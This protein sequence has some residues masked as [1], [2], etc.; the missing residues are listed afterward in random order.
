MKLATL[1][2]EPEQ[3]GHALDEAAEQVTERRRSRPRSSCTLRPTTCTSTSAD[4][5]TA[6]LR[7]LDADAPRHALI[8]TGRAKIAM[9]SMSRLIFIPVIDGPIPR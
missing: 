6:A 8:I 7:C 5:R 4:Y 3:S 9:C 1:Q 2:A